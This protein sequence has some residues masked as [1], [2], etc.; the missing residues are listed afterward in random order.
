M[1]SGEII[2]LGAIAGVT[3][4][5]GLPVGRVRGLSPRFRALPK[6]GAAGVLVF[7]LVETVSHAFEPVEHAVEENEWGEFALRAPIFLIA[8]A[9][10][11]LGLVYYDRWIHRRPAG[12]S[13]GPGA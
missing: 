7:P 11:L 1:S 6:P 4:F 12:K 5:L 13:A 10:G 8:F 3:I 9:V 2:V